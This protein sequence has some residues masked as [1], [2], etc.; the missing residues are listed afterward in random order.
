MKELLIA[1]T[2][3]EVQLNEV[4]QLARNC[5]ACASFDIPRE[6]CMEHN[7]R[8]PASVIVIGCDNFSDL[9]PF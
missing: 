6:I 1:I 7:A 2:L 3:L 9:V 5:V 8:P 4:K